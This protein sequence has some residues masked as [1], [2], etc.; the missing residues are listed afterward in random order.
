MAKYAI[1]NLNADKVNIS[2]G[3]RVDLEGVS[4]VD[5]VSQMPMA[6]LREVILAAG[7]EL[8]IKVHRIQV[9]E[10]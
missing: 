8:C 1:T 5:L 6:M 3:L 7:E 2:H 4:A 9:S 10:E